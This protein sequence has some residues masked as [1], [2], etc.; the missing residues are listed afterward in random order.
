MKINNAE[1]D[2]EDLF[3]QEIGDSH[4][5]LNTSIL[6]GTNPDVSPEKLTNTNE[7]GIDIASNPPANYIS[8]YSTSAAEHDHIY[9]ILESLG[10]KPEFVVDALN[11]NSPTLRL[12]VAPATPGAIEENLEIPANLAALSEFLKKRTI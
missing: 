2:I 12:K 5:M 10:F 4:Q 6:E 9:S 8:A 7:A 1:I 3:D 11:V